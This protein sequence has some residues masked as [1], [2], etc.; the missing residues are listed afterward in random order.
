MKSWFMLFRHLGADCVN[1]KG[2]NHL[3]LRYPDV[4]ASLYL[5]FPWI[6]KKISSSHIHTLLFA[7][8]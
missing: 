5:S 6:Y 4:P 7:S 3:S 8:D 2:E 1:E